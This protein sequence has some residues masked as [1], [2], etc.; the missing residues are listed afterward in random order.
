MIG[1]TFAFTA[2]DGKRF[3]YDAVRFF[4]SFADDP[5][6]A[7]GCLRAAADAG[8]GTQLAVPGS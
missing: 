1:D 4:D 5:A 6:Y 2:G 7:L 3:V 8:A